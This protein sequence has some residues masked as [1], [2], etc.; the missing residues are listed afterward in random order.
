MRSCGTC[1]ACC[2]WP[3]IPALAK[4]QGETCP[5]LD[6]CGYGCTQ[7]FERPDLCRR[8]ECAWVQGHGGIGDQPDKAG[9]LIDLRDSQFGDVLVA[10]D[11]G[12]PA[13][14][15]RRAIRRISEDAG[16]PCLLVAADDPERVMFV[17]GPDDVVRKAVDAFPELEALT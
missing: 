15:K 7:Y 1:S 4:P 10:R 12:G 17:M 6:A 5:R 3:E 13:N 9:V 8:Y 14:K 2:R 16:L 11:L